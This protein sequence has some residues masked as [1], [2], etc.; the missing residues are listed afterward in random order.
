MSNPISKLTERQEEFIKKVMEK[1]GWDHD[2]TREQIEETKA[3]YG[4]TYK[5][6]FNNALYEVPL[7]ERK[8]R[9]EKRELYR[10]KRKRYIE[11]VSKEAGWNVDTARKNMQAAFDEIGCTFFQYCYYQYYNMTAE[12]QK[13]HFEKLQKKQEAKKGTREKMR[14]KCI[15]SIMKE[16]GCDY[17]TAVKSLEKSQAKTGCTYVEFMEYSFYNKTLEEQD[18]FFLLSHTDKIRGKYNVDVA[19][20]RTIADKE[21]ANILLAEFVNRKWCP[22][23]ETSFEDFKKTFEGV[24]KIFYKPLSL[25]WGRGA[26]PYEINDDNIREVYDELLTMPEGVV[27]E[28]VV[29]HDEM[30]RMSPTAVNTIRM[31]TLSSKEPI[32]AEGNH[33][34]ICYATLKMGG[35]TGCV[36][37][38]HG[39]GVGAAVDLATGKLCTDAVDDFG[40]T[41]ETHPVTGTTIKGFQIPY[42]NEAVDMLKRAVEKYNIQGYFGWDVA[43]TQNGPKLIEVN[44]RPGPTLAVVPYYWTEGK[45][46]KEIMEKY[47]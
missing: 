14:N 13:A 31:A 3:K 11:T 39:G 23:L 40:N 41:Y 25:S 27:E 17:D 18:T 8:A 9:F 15:G 44:G 45:G 47:L 2:Y 32:D 5:Q 42:F 28:F 38:L 20:N 36:D 12:E 19:F 26:K 46:M 10:E 22:N 37:N 1:T 6:F 24:G 21:K 43:I 29:Q 33:F 7:D 35:K 30:N 16:K 4:Y 34:A